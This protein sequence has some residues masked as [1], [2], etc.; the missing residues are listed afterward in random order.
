MR[1]HDQ[2]TNRAAENWKSEKRKRKR[3]KKPK[4]LR[5]A[6]RQSND[7]IKASGSDILPAGTWLRAMPVLER[8]CCTDGVIFFVSPKAEID[9][10]PRDLA[11][12]DVPP[13][14]R[15]RR[16]VLPR[17][18][19]RPRRGIA[20]ASHRL[21]FLLYSPTAAPPVSLGFQELHG[22]ADRGGDGGTGKTLLAPFGVAGLVSTSPSEP[23]GVVY[24]YEEDNES[25]QC[26]DS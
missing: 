1:Y 7:G 22:W 5:M 25:K 19:H 11:I 16:R 20:A 2:E 17:R 26:L 3:S 8:A 4:T 18:H 9:T 13:Y 15:L 14:R 21:S 6:L 23:T 12:L 24:L 10:G